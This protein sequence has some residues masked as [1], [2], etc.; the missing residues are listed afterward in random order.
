[1]S[2]TDGTAYRIGELA[3]KA[4]VSADTLRYY[5]RAGLI[6]PPPRSAG[7][8][9][10]YS[11][12]DIDRL[13]FI[14]RAQA[15]GFSLSEI[16]DLLDPDVTGGGRCRQVRDLLTARLH[17]VD[18]R[19]GELQA[20]RRSLVAARR[21]CD[22]AL[23]EGPQPACCPVVEEGTVTASRTFPTPLTRKRHG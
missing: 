1:M 2:P 7:G 4:G 21:R 8:F 3:E 20:F 12:D 22:K 15:V 6:A 14:R 11:N 17:Q 23:L 9:R 13:T 16:R 18:A 19:L 10:L 5:E